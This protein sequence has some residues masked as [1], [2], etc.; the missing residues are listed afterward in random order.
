MKEQSWNNEACFF[1]IFKVIIENPPWNWKNIKDHISPRKV[2][3]TYENFEVLI[4]NLTHCK[5]S[6]YW[7]LAESFNC[8]CLYELGSEFLPKQWRPGKHRLAR[9]RKRLI[10]DFKVS[11]AHVRNINSRKTSSRHIESLRKSSLF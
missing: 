5:K 8:V 10:H 6:S 7:R 11:T 9:S 3:I 2:P 4:I 1:I